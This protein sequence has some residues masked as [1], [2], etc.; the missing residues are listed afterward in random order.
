MRILILL[1]YDLCLV[2]NPLQLLLL[3]GFR[4]DSLIKIRKCYKHFR[5][6]W[7]VEWK[8]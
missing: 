2:K 1:P 6:I 4:F 8:S 5:L 7:T 3:F